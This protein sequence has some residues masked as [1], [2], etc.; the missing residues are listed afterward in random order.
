MTH[1]SVLESPESLETVIRVPVRTTGSL[2]DITPA[3]YASEKLPMDIISST[4]RIDF[5]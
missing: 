1:I 3:V 5:T 4:T 2:Y